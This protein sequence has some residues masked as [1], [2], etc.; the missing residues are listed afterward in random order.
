MKNED[1]KMGPAEDRDD[2]TSTSSRTVKFDN[3]AYAVIDGELRRVSGEHV[4]QTV[5][6]DYR[7]GYIHVHNI[8]TPLVGDDLVPY[9]AADGSAAKDYTLVSSGV[10]DGRLNCE[11][12]RTLVNASAVYDNVRSNLIL[13]TAEG[14][15]VDCPVAVI[16]VTVGERPDAIH[17]DC[18]WFNLRMPWTF[19]NDTF[20]HMLQAVFTV[21]CVLQRRLY[22]VSANP[23]R[24]GDV[25]KAAN[26]N[27]AL[28]LLMSQKGVSF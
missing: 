5:R 28:R 2:Y 20:W 25:A 6:Q 23:R 22:F 24:A 15:S 13:L 3:P 4:S 7:T 9:T 19:S 12:F 17:F 21:S 26:L 8:R 27:R 14:V 1:F 10:K 16:T 11:E 18:P